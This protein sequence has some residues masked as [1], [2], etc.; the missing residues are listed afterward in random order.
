MLSI[1]LVTG[2]QVNRTVA[3]P[4]GASSSMGKTV[5]ALLIGALFWIVM[6]VRRV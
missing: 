5:K 1:M 3:I 2:Y 6:G 4:G